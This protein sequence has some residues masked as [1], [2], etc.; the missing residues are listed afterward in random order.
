M[1]F[2]REASTSHDVCNLGA[3]MEK[4]R[5]NASFHEEVS[6]LKTVSRVEEEPPRFVKNFYKNDTEHIELTDTAGLEHR[7]DKEAS[8]EKYSDTFSSEECLNFH[9]EDDEGPL[10]PL[11]PFG[12]D[13]AVGEMMKGPDLSASGNEMHQAM[14][15]YHEIILEV[16]AEIPDIAGSENRMGREARRGKCNGR[17]S[18]EE[19][20]NLPCEAEEEPLIPVESLGEYQANRETMKGTD[21]PPSENEMHVF[22]EEDHVSILEGSVE[23]PDI[24]ESGIGREASRENYDDKFC[25]G[26]CLNLIAEV[27]DK[28]PGL[29]KPFSEEQTNR[30]KMKG[31]TSNGGKSQFATQDH[32]LSVTLDATPQSLLR[33]A[34]GIRKH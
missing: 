1:D 4:L 2:E 10:C 30:E 7:M 21:L 20:M 26:E 3:S 12:E 33:D 18:S 8:R 9:C 19:G 13:Q 6:L 11:Q 31:T 17:F 24:A 14:E 28:S 29:I 34:S 32:Q 27:E 22:M 16:S 23:V 25:Q 5:Y 15:E